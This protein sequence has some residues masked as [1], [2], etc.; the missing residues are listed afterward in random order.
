MSGC[1][2]MH[3]VKEM[4]EQRP[5]MCSV[6]SSIH[7]FIQYTFFIVAKIYIYHEI[8]HFKPLLSIQ[9]SSIKYSHCCAAFTIHLHNF[10]ISFGKHILRI[11]CFRTFKLLQI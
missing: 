4:V 11:H 9:F 10:F 2:W 6:R 7:L 8:H 3:R 5:C 1:L